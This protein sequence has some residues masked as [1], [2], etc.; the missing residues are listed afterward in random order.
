[1]NLRKQ[2]IKQQEDFIKENVKLE[3]LREQKKLEEEE[4]LKKI[5]EFAKKKQ[6]LAD[7][8]VRKEGEKFNEKQK[9]RQVMIDKQIE[10]L[11]NLKNREDEILEK[12]RNEAEKKLENETKEKKRRFNEFK[13]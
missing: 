12:Q 4:N 11:T 9:R 8:K 3:K 10:Y 6:D 1:M 7:L 2:A 5:K 13:V